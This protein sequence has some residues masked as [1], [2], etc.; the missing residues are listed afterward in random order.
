MRIGCST[1]TF[2]PQT[3]DE[4][5]DRIAGLGFTVIDI[6]AVPGWCDHV[7]LAEPPLG[8]TDR[9]A[10]LVRSHGFD[11]AGLQTIPWHPDAL[12]DPAELRRRYTVAADL[13]QALGADAWVV[14]ANG[15]DA[16]AADPRA[17]GLD[18]FKRTI[19]MAAELADER[20]LRLA[21]EAPHRGTLAETMPEVRQLLEAADLPRL[22]V[23]LD[24][25]HLLNSG[26]TAAEVLGELGPRVY[27]VALRDGVH[28][29]RFCTPGDGDFDFADFFGQL[30]AAGYPGDVTLELE[31]AHPDDSA[32]VR[33]REAARARE[34]LQPLLAAAV[35]P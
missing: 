1:L 6:V 16:N 8:Q 4:A 3:L 11:V 33:A 30:T 23:D 5:L 9:V 22:G 19:T 25:S 15:P 17:G 2:V 13:A 21:V 35:E 28:G 29:G 10:D 20:D 18:R 26:A 34:Y 14:D 32:T 27:H 12:D 31:P 24:T 7:L